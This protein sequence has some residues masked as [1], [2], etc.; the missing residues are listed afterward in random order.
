MTNYNVY[1][2][3]CIG[4]HADKPSAF[5]VAVALAL[6]PLWLATLVQVTINLYEVF[7]DRPLIPTVVAV[8]VAIASVIN[9]CPPDKLYCT[10]YLIFPYLES[11]LGLVHPFKR[12]VTD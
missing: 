1:S 11:R 10:I 3:T 7:A 5:V 12:I 4:T 2:F 8:V 9:S 6:G